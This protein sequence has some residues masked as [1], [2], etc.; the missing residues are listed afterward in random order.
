MSY[1]ETMVEL[2]QAKGLPYLVQNGV[3]WHQYRGMVEPR[4]PLDKVAKLNAAEAQ[5]IGAHF[6]GRLVRWYGEVN[7]NV[8]ADAWYAVVCDQMVDPNSWTSKQRK[9][10]RKGQEAA[11]VRIIPLEQEA[12]DIYRVYRNA[13]ARYKNSTIQIQEAKSF[14]RE[15]AIEAAF[16]SLLQY[17]GVYVKD[18]LVGY[19]KIY[20]FDQQEAMIAVTKLDPA[21][22]KF[23]ISELLTYERSQYLLGDLQVG[24]IRSGFRNLE[25]QTEV[26]DFFQRFGYYN[27][28]LP[29]HIQ[30]LGMLKM[31]MPFLRPLR[32]LPWPGPIKALLQQDQFR[33]TRFNK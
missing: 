2:Y 25:H 7:P 29:L 26:Q 32:G 31:A 14:L 24:I 19:S 27:V 22:L 20:L 21:F 23:R 1:L 8:P 6:G 5:G 16:P 3:F 12:E 11:S 9:K 17:Q 28:A 30:Y 33:S 4:G 13:H 15:V 18:Q 10:L